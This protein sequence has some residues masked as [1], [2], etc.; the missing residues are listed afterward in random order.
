MSVY[1]ACFPGL[2]SRRSV[3]AVKAREATSSGWRGWFPEIKQGSGQSPREEAPLGGAVSIRPTPS[4][5][6]RNF[7]PAPSLVGLWFLEEKMHFLM[8]KRSV[9]LS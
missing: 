8:R 2:A 7:T 3:G 1:T 6:H 4:G 5:H 9:P